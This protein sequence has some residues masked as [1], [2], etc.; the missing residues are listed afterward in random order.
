MGIALNIG[1]LVPPFLI[2]CSTLI[3]M[4]LFPPVTYIF[5]YYFSVS[6]GYFFTAKSLNFGSQGSNFAPFLN[7]TLSLGKATHFCDFGNY[8]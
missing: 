3:S 5:H 8:T 1:E 7:F 4:I 2:A 6:I